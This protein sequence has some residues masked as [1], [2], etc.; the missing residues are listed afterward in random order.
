MAI[1]R[2]PFSDD[3]YHCRDFYKGDPRE[4]VIRKRWR[5]FQRWIDLHSTITRMSILD[6]LAQLSW[7]LGYNHKVNRPVSCLCCM[8]LDH[9][10]RQ[11]HGD[12]VE[13]CLLFL[14]GIVS[15]YRECAAHKSHDGSLGYDGPC[16]TVFEL[17]NKLDSA[18]ARH[19]FAVGWMMR[20]R[21]LR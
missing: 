14:S 12:S 2:G 18:Q 15:L 13:M 7:K 8:F 5:E 1:I 11:P 9:P 4:D 16:R 20:L 10:I 3:P 17:E 19:N 6:Q 21:M